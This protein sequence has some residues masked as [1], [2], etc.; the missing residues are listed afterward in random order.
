MFLK[1]ECF[2]QLQTFQPSNFK[3]GTQNT[4]HGTRNTEPRTIISQHTDPL[5]LIH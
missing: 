3:H 5:P 4:E 1:A 2:P